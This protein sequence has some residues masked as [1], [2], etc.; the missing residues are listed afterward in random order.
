MLRNIKITLVTTVVALALVAI[1]PTTGVAADPP[2][3]QSA[4]AQS[5]PCH[6]SITFF[7][8]WYDGLC[9][10]DGDGNVVIAPPTSPKN[11]TS[12]TGHQLGAWLAIIAMNLVRML[13]YVVGY[14]SLIFI[15]YGGFKYM[16]QGDNANGTAAARKTIQNAII[17]LVISILSVSIVSFVAGR[18]SG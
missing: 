13:L 5:D 17:G 6:K 3:D 16:T 12:D 2:A 9:S 10:V 15:I 18:I 4:P 11:G 7:P 8:R 1:V 14:A